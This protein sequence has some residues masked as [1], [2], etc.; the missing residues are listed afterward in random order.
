MAITEVPTSKCM[1]NLSSSDLGLDPYSL[2]APAEMSD[3]FHGFPSHA[4][5]PAVAQKK[6][7]QHGILVHGSK[8]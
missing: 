7:H 1:A 6:W 5:N 3:L 8:D 2:M 4:K